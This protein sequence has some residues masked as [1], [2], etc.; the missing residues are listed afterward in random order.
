[1]AIRAKFKGPVDVDGV[2]IE[3]LH[4]I[5]ARDLDEDEDW[6]PLDADQREAVRNSGLYDVK[7]NAQMRSSRPSASATAAEEDKPAEPEQSEPAESDADSK[8]N[9]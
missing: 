9:D 3:F 7:T 4:G 5:P 1:M 6:E 8:G 2:A